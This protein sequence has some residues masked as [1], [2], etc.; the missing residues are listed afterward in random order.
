MAKRGD[1]A[2]YNGFGAAGMHGDAVMQPPTFGQ[3]RGQELLWVQ[4]IPRFI[5]LLYQ[6]WKQLPAAALAYPHRSCLLRL[7]PPRFPAVAPPVSVRRR[8]RQKRRKS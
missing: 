6:R 1:Q 5:L 4:L 2:L 3:V 7:P 8:R